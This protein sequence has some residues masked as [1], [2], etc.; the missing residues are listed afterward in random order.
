LGLGCRTAT[1]WQVPYLAC[2]GLIH[3]TSDP[4]GKIPQADGCV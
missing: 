1:R 4:L 3:L 2:I